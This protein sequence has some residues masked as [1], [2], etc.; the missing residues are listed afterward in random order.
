MTTLAGLQRAASS[1]RVFPFVCGVLEKEKKK[2]QRPYNDE[3]IF[4]VAVDDRQDC[5]GVVVGMDDHDLGN[6]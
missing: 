4:K 5:R 3:R 1:E 6:P 2:D